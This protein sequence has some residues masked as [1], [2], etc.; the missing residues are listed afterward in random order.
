MQRVAVEGALVRVLHHPAGVHDRDLVADVRD[1]TQIVRDQDHR[2][3]ELLFQLL[4]QLQDL[5]L[6]GHVQRRGRLVR[7]QK[8]GV[9]GKGD[10]D[11]HALLHTA[12]ELVRIVVHPLA[13]DAHQLQHV[14]RLP[15]GLRLGDV[16][17]QPDHLG[18][19][20]VHRHDGVEARHRVLEDHRDLPAADGAHLR[21][22]LPQQV[23]PLEEDLPG[24]HHAG[25]RRD[26][27]HDAERRGRLARARLADEAQGLPAPQP[28]V[29]ALHRMHR[30]AVRHVL[31]RQ[32]PDL[33]QEIRLV[34][35]SFH[36]RPFH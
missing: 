27:A 33:Q 34:L 30:P 14:P 31:D 2:G 11:H 36:I 23:L 25:R 28:E 8:P 13:P 17:V 9:A 18:D 4:H 1:D 12:G 32:V 20:P 24:P 21:L 3:A 26:Q 29:Q 5:G 10:G 7:D 15:Q 19:L 6:D 35:G 22:A 16:P